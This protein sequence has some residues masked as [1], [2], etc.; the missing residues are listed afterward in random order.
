MAESFTGLD[1]VVIGGYIV[2]LFVLGWRVL[3]FV[4]GFCAAKI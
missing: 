1:W 4:L 2:L 3:L